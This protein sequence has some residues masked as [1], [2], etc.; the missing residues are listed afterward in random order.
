MAVRPDAPANDHR[1][2]L[3]RRGGC[4]ACSGLQGQQTPARPPGRMSCAAPAGRWR[5]ITGTPARRVLLRCRGSSPRI[6]RVFRSPGAG[7]G[8]LAVDLGGG[9]L[10]RYLPIFASGGLITRPDQRTVV[11]GSAMAT[12]WTFQEPE[13]FRWTYSMR[14]S[15]GKGVAY[16]EIDGTRRRLRH[17]AGVL[18]A[19]ARR[20][21]R[22]AARG[23][24]RRDPAQGVPDHRRRS[25]WSRT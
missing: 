23:L 5:G 15:H 12:L 4:L 1:Y 18:P 20:R 9:A 14:A 2:A 3:C 24:G 10:P 25:I 21:D 17:H 6:L 13:T 8:R 16:A 22:Q 19:R 7:R 11:D